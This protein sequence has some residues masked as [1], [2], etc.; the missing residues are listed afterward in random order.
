FPL[1]EVEPG[2]SFEVGGIQVDTLLA[3]HPVPCMSIRLPQLG[4]VYTADTGLT[5]ELV[6]F[7]RGAKLLL[8]EATYPTEEG[9]DF[10]RHGHMGGF[11]AGKL[12]HEAGVEQLVVTHLS[13]IDQADET[14]GH[15]RKQ[16][17][18]TVCFAAPGQ[19]YAL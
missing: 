1:T 6:E 7:S 12:A 14:E 8:A 5:D 9:R 15:V 2:E 17:D 3:F 16:F 19:R 10:S 4:F 11:E 13:D 18:G